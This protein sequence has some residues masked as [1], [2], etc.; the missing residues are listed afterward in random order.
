MEERPADRGGRDAEALSL[1]GLARRSGRAIVGTKAVRE[2]AKSGSLH[3]ALLSRDA[4]ENA[5]N[6][7][8][9]VFEATGTAW[10][11]CGQGDELA[12]SVGR[13]RAVV[14]GISDRRLAAR[15]G[16]ILTG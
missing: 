8:V 3:L 1:L 15:I 14:V 13:D 9:P 4:G 12:R 7:V 11:E 10:S 5:R 2:A 16:E 6:R